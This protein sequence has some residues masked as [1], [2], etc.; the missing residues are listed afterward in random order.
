MRC[1]CGGMNND[2]N[3]ITGGCGCADCRRFLGYRPTVRHGI[4]APASPVRIWLAQFGKHLASHTCDL[5]LAESPLAASTILLRVER[6][7]P[8]VFIEHHPTM[9]D[10]Q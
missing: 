4:L 6:D 3:Y 7:R 10:C 8:A 5:A 9:L 2:H 1:G